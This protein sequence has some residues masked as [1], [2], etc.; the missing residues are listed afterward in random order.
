MRRQSG[1]TLVELMIVVAI[2]GIL[3]G[4]AYP[5]YTNYIIRA[6]RAVA[7]QFMLNVAQRQEQFFL[8]ARRYA[9]SVDELNMKQPQETA[10]RYTFAITLTA[11]PPPT[12][13]ITATAAGSQVGD[14]NLT[15]DS[16]GNKA[17]S[18]KWMK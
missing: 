18:E 2:I 9:T 13:A 7:Q 8:D 14:G 11:G 6:N 1:F 15:L 4:I 5:S 10:G 16:L 17:P 12:F 3:A